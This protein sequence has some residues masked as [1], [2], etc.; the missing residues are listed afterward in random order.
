LGAWDRADKRAVVEIVCNNRTSNNIARFSRL[1][2]KTVQKL[3]DPL[4]RTRIYHDGW[5]AYEI[6]DDPASLYEG[7]TV[8]HSDAHFGH[9]IYSTNRI[10][11]FWADLR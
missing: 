3:T 2:I 7:F 10:E 8:V 6:F 4:L 1:Y 11:G 9:K 5:R